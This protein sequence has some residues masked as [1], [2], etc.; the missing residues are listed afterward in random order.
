MIRPRDDEPITGLRPNQIPPS[1]EARQRFDAILAETSGMWDD[2][3]GMV[4]V[5]TIDDT[6]ESPASKEPPPSIR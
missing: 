3:E 5:Q 6:F 2:K 4:I 1:A